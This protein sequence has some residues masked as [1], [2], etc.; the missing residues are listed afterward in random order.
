MRKLLLLTLAAMWLVGIVV[1]G[2]EI[3]KRPVPAGQAMRVMAP[4]GTTGAGWVQ[5]NSLDL[6]YQYYYTQY[7]PNGVAWIAGYTATSSARKPI[8]YRTTDNGA[9]WKKVTIPSKN[10]NN[11]DRGVFYARDSS[12]AL[13]GTFDGKMLRTTNAGTTWD[14]VYYYGAGNGWFDGI[15]FMTAD[16]VFAFG[17]DPGDNSGL[18][19]VKSTNA[20]LTWT[21]ITNLP[22]AELDGSK[23]WSALSTFGQAMDIKGRTIWL[24][25]YMGASGDAWG[26]IVRSTDGGAT[27]DSWNAVLSGDSTNNYYLR[28]INFLDQNIGFGV[29]KTPDGTNNAYY[30][31]TTDGGRTWGA[32]KKPTA[33]P[34][35]SQELRSL[36]PI[37]GT[38]S[39]MLVGNNF[40]ASAGRSWVSSDTGKTWTEIPAQGKELYNTAF[41]SGTQGFAGGNNNLLKYTVQNVRKVTFNMNTAT[42]PD[43]LPVTG[44]VT[45]MRGEVTNAGGFSPITWGNDAQNNFTRVGGD[46]WK[47]DLFLQV[48]DTLSYKYVIQHPAG[49]TGWENGVVP[50]NFPTKTNANRSYVVADKDTVLPVEFWNNGANSQPQYFRPYATVNDTF[51]TVYFRVNML[52]PISSGTFG[53]NNDKDTVGVRGGGPTGSDL[54]WSPTFYLT[55]EAAASNWANTTVQPTSFWSGGLKFPKS[56]VNAGDSIFYKFLI[57]YDWGRDE[58]GGG[59][60]NR[61][62]FVPVGKKDTTLYFSYYNNERPS[63]R[64]NPDTVALTFRVNLAQAAASGGFDVT[65]DTI[66]VRSGYF[67]TSADPSRSRQMVKLTPTIFQFVDTI[68]T[69]KTK[70]LD[71]QYYVVRSGVDTRENYY[72]FTYNG[73]T[74]SEAERR[75]FLIPTTASK[76]VMT[77]INDTSTSV[78]QAR[79]QPNFKNSRVLAKR[80]RV[81]Y[82]V[83]M[84]PAFYTLAFGDS[85]FDVQSA[86]RTII[87]K[88][89]DSLQKWGVW[90]NGTALGDW[91]NPTGDAWGVGLRDNLQKKMYDNG[92]NGDRVANDT[93]WTRDVICAP[94]SISVGDKG[95]VGQV[96][97]FGVYGGDNEGGRGGFGNNHVSNIVDTDTLWTM[98]DQ[99]GSINPAYYRF[100][101]YDNKRPNVPTAVGDAPV[102]LTFDLSQNYPNPFNPATQITYSL[103]VASKVELKVFNVLGQVV[104]TLVD[105]VKPAGAYTARFDATNFATGMYIYKFQAGSFSSVKKM[106]LVK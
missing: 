32:S 62:F 90:I 49:N 3:D 53:F 87:P 85:L 33:E 40:T 22:A 37:P 69:A 47:K 36:K 104:A 80:V 23:M 16:T 35:A 100:W 15:R 67:N 63:V 6:T 61:K 18:H 38:N 28:S 77:F 70:N 79:R 45:Q 55:R 91:A 76:S 19:V 21:K 92:T 98:V 60:P 81:R 64:A 84:K 86:F 106:L 71:Y 25:T 97:K 99:F 1:A 83:N 20:G 48:G 14:S 94:E 11:A 51:M 88:D 30:T 101:D 95:R 50:A 46:Y 2:E 74:P 42:V 27:W 105:E 9:T 54:K 68:I 12:L 103:P 44:S 56:A 93:I 5:L 65:K 102:P 57:G 39:L 75:Q 59:A 89:K 72:N 13:Y 96:F 52:G 4:L 73:P 7:L 26:R 29:D 82:E 10:V 66:Q 31:I 43:T 41:I 78:T 17:D 24:A 58:L 8:A 34:S